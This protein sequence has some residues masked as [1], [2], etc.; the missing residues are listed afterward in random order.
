MINLATIQPTI[1]ALL[2]QNL[3]LKLKPLTNLTS[4][5]IFAM[6]TRIK[7]R[8]IQAM[9]N[10]LLTL[11]REKIQQEQSEKYLRLKLKYARLKYVYNKLKQSNL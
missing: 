6:P 9:F 3:K 10:G 4:I 8:D 7:D 2:K 1:K 11:L 5:K